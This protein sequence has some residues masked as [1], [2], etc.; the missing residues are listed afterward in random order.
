VDVATGTSKKIVNHGEEGR[1]SPDGT[2]ILYLSDKGK[3]G[4]QCD[5]GSCNYDKRVYLAAD[6]G[7]GSHRLMAGGEH[8]IVDGA[9]FSP[10]GERVVF[11]SDRNFV[12]WF[13]IGFEIYSAG[14]DGSCLTWLTNGSP[15]SFDPDFSPVVGTDSDPGQ[16][17]EAGRPVVVTPIPSRHP[18]V[19]G[20]KVSWPKL[21]LGTVYRGSVL[22]YPTRD[23]EDL[24]YFDC[25]TFDP[26][27][28]GWVYTQLTSWGICEGQVRDRLERGAYNGMIR[29]RGALLLKP[30]DDR[31]SG[32]QSLLVTGGQTVGI[33]VQ[34][35]HLLKAS[36]FQEHLD[37]VDALRPVGRDDLAGADLAGDILDRADIGKARHVFESLRQLG[38]V[39]EVAKRYSLEPKAVRA[40]VAFN[41]DLR[42]YGNYRTRKCASP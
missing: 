41:R 23:G 17:G 2:G 11:G 12:G 27:G 38:S 25:S 40:Y 5:E 22:S 9:D 34:D 33:G 29:H 16:C 4:K 32:R 26:A 24:T 39:K 30:A 8:G 3:T 36:S 13:G 20:R 6:D 15:S 35:Y 19:D 42:K 18:V 1:W 28:C 37:V 21:W 31:Y 10:D 7:S 14:T